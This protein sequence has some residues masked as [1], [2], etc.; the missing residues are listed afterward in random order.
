MR[1]PKLSKIIVT[2]TI[3]A[4]AL[5][6]ALG[7]V[8]STT[9][10]SASPVPVS[11]RTFERA[12][13]MD[14]V[15]VKIHD[16]NNGVWSNTD[17]PSP[18]PQSNCAP[19]ADGVDTNLIPYHL[20]ALVTQTLRGEIAVVDLTAGIVVDVARTQPGINFIPVGNNPTDVVATADGK[21]VYVAAAELNKP[22]IYAIPGAR[23]IGDAQGVADGKPATTITEWPVCSLPQAPGRMA[24]VPVQGAAGV[25]EGGAD[26]GDSDGGVAPTQQLAV[27]LP[28]DTSTSA[29]LVTID[30]TAFA[31]TVGDGSLAPCPI[32]SAIEL[33]NVVPPTFRSGSAWANGL[34]YVDGGVNL[35]DRASG[36]DEPQLP[37]WTIGASLPP[38]PVVSDAGDAGD[39]S[40]S[41]DASSLD[42]DP[43]DATDGSSFDAG[44][45]DDG[46]DAEA[47]FPLKR[48]P[49]LIAHG[50]GMA[51]DGRFLYIGD[52]ALPIVHAVDTLGGKLSELAP[53]V[54]SS[55]ITPSR[56]VTTTEIA[57]SPVTHDFKRY[58]YALDDRDGTII[59]Y[60]A[61]DP[62]TAKREPMVRPNAEL[63]PAQPPDR[64]RFAQPVTAFS[65]VRHDQPLQNVY[66]GKPNFVQRTGLQCN[67]NRLVERNDQ[68]SSLGPF[69]DT[70][71]NA[72]DVALGAYY[73]AN[74]AQNIE[75]GPARLRGVFAFATL[76]T[77][78]VVVIDVDDWDAACRRP[79]HLTSPFQSSSL[80]IPQQDGPDIDPYHWSDTTNLAAG[81][82]PSAIVVDTHE[83]FFP[84][85]APNRPRSYYFLR[86]DT[87][88]GNHVPYVQG[89]AALLDN[90]APVDAKQRGLPTLISTIPNFTPDKGE[91]VSAAEPNVR[92]SFEDP[93]VHVDQDWTITYEGALPGFDGVAA[94]LATTDDFKS[95]SFSSSAGLFCRRGVEDQRI[96]QARV[97][98]MLTEKTATP[99]VLPIRIADRLGDYV[100]ITDNILPDYDP[101]WSLNGADGQPPS[102]W[103]VPM[104]NDPS[105]NLKS[106]SAETRYQVCA[107][108]FGGGPAASSQ[109]DFPILEAYDDHLVLGRYLYADTLTRPINGRVIAPRDTAS[110]VDYKLAQC[111]FHN[112]AHFRIRT[113]AQWVS[114]GTGAG[115]LHHISANATNACVRSSNP[116]EVLLNSRIVERIGAIGS[117]ERNSAFAVRNPIFSAALRG[118]APPEGSLF[119]T[120]STRDLAWNFSLRGGFLSRT[121]NLAAATTAVVPQSM[122]FIDSIGR[123]AVV[124]GSSQGLVLISLDSIAIV[125]TPYF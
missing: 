100:Q 5:A 7:L 101:Y 80:E 29:K 26:A 30:L 51:F 72:T 4:A 108:K 85:S 21:T 105:R 110:Q 19:V 119:F 9:S 24:L 81:T 78:Q 44:T 14:V 56:I 123:L 97:A 52:D 16:V 103:D 124:D 27:L 74:I 13:R 94:T 58:L 63:T 64:V 88:T 60:D 87:I 96:S 93:T 43:T 71:G 70:S 47:Q 102:C 109:R 22:A 99:D 54:A 116:R 95:L 121:V 112:Q 42:A 23:V 111:C 77:G 46:A 41:S 38:L 67:P 53:Y 57:V 61:S 8:S 25:G 33:T 36:I 62:L 34:P 55:L 92:L 86:N 118:P 40:D 90:G 125:G 75:L 48:T 32:S 39:S 66:P 76:T 114:I 91:T 82:N 31:N 49:G 11:V 84:V 104:V 18:V 98:T 73:R 10:C 1:F 79:S 83:R 69:T 2:A 117:V 89:Q 50:R 45:A 37:L 113:G 12:G 68:S 107:D 15:C 17:P 65:F 120:N 6:G 59:I 28:G 20:F 3:G 115:Y 122:A 106:E 35:F